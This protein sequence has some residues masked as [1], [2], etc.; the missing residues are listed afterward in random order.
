[1]KDL[2][3]SDLVNGI[4]GRLSTGPTRIQ[5]LGSSVSLGSTRKDEPAKVKDE[6]E[7]VDGLEGEE[8]NQVKGEPRTS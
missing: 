8:G 1:M 6:G 3:E 4:D 5:P 2:S 7:D